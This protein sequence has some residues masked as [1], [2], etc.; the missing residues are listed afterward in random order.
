MQ[1]S[2]ATD[3]DHRAHRHGTENRPGRRREV[4][5]SRLLL[6]AFVISELACLAIVAAVVL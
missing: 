1:E 6:A 3:P 2:D 4:V 5:S